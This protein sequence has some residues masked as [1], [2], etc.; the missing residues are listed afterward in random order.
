[1]L[2][3]KDTKNLLIS[4]VPCGL[5]HKTG[6]ISRPSD[7]TFPPFLGVFRVTHMP[8]TDSGGLSP[9]VLVVAHETVSSEGHPRCNGDGP[10][11]R[12]TRLN[13]ERG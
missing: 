2:I 1:M 6:K 9:L 7:T 13:R 5:F 4:Q 12:T 11:T 10:L 8:S 3:S